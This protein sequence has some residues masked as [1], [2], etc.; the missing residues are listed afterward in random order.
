[1]TNRNA[2]ILQEVREEVAREVNSVRHEMQQIRC[3]VQDAIVKLTDSFNGLRDQSD[4]Q[5]QLVSKLTHSMDQEA[6]QASEGV[7]IR[8][9]VTETDKILRTFVDHIILVSRQSMEMVHRVDALS[10]QM[11][12][13]VTIIKDINGIA[14]Q[15]NVLSLNARIVA[16]RAG[17]AGR[18]FSV[19]ADEVRK[20]ARNSHEFSDR[21]SE[22][23]D[24][25]KENIL[26][27]KEIIEV[28]ASKDMSFAIESKGRVDYMMGEVNAIDQ[29][30]TETIQKVSV[31]A[32]DIA[33]RVGIAVMSLQFED[34]VTQLTQSMERKFTVLEHFGSLLPVELL[35]HE[36]LADAL[37]GA[38][39]EQKERFNTADRQAVQQTSMDEGDIELF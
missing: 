37:Q 28:M 7:N 25:A 34:M 29:F 1:M 2:Q 30:T 31:I 35:T 6:D 20:L 16:A 11:Q 5:Y 33:M 3:L 13:V 21:I 18:A 15:T 8:K 9:F 32:G 12:E 19:V 17:Q 22:V 23:V 27:T 10:S 24:Q 4:A 39:E 14:E 36:S 26:A 38:L